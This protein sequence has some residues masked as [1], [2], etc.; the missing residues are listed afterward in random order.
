LSQGDDEF[1][2]AAES[3][4]SSFFGSDGDRR[5][6]AACRTNGVRDATHGCCTAIA[7]C[8]FLF[9]RSENRTGRACVAEWKRFACSGISCSDNTQ[10]TGKFQ[11]LLSPDIRQ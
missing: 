6:E 10:R 11:A 8:Y 4:D 5:E 3:R 9:N 7:S 1:D 2:R